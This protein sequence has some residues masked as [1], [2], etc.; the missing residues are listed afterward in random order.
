MGGGANEQESLADAAVATPGSRFPNM[1]SAGLHGPRSDARRDSVVLMTRVIKLVISA[2]FYVVAVGLLR[3]G[4]QGQCVVLYYHAVRGSQQAAF[5]RQIKQIRK[6]CDVVSPAAAR[7]A[8]PGTRSAA[9][10]FDDGFRSFVDHALPV[11]QALR[12]PTGMFVPSGNLGRR[13]AWEMV[14]GALDSH[15]IVMS[16]DDLRAL[17]A[18]VT[19]GSHSV[20]HQD[21]SCLDTRSIDYELTD[22]RTNLQSITGRPV[23]LLA[24]PYGDYNE[25]VIARCRD[26]GYE[27]V[28]TSAPIPV[29]EG[30]DPYV[31]GRVAVTPDDWAWEFRLKMLGA[32]RWVPRASAVKQWLMR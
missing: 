30:E 20:H 14:D 17:P 4:S 29:R 10:T 19:V 18:L 21:L 1:R 11:L 31:V 22:S 9:V 28:F 25:E 7:L 32:Y 16:E 27:R 15:E 3:R 26:A 8:R 24:L 13:P 5:A 23:T 2:A 12:I 6:Y